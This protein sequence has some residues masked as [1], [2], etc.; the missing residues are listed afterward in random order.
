MDQTSREDLLTILKTRFEQH[1]DRHPGFTW[2]AVRERLEAHPDRLRSL[3]EMERTGGEP[4]VV[5]VDDR[6]GAYVFMDCSPESPAG[7]R[8]L[9][10]DRKA[11]DERK[12]NK[13]ESSAME[14]ASAMGAAL[15]TPDQYRDLQAFGPFDTRTSSWLLTPQAIR[16]LGGAMFGDHRF[17]TTW[18]YHNGADSYYAA[19]GFRC[20][21]AV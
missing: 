16:D 14:F 10:Y 1:M 3:Q 15:L 9:C 21:L 19:R 12:K 6:T 17:G 5:G 4:D 13:P 20:R 8:S 18:F 11:L 7:R 2:D